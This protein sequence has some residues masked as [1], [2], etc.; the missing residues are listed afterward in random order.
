MIISEEDILKAHTCLKETQGDLEDAALLMGITK[1]KLKEIIEGSPVLNSVYGKRRKD[2]PY[3]PEQGAARSDLP[4]P[5]PNPPAVRMAEAMV[6]QEASLGQPLAALGFNPTEVKNI[7]SIEE[8]AGNHF[9]RSLSMLHGGMVKTSLRLIFQAQE[10]ERKY[11]NDPSLEQK[12]RDSWWEIY[13]RILENLRK[14]NEQASKAAL[15]RALIKG[16]KNGRP[17][18][19]G[20]QS[21]GNLIQITNPQNVTVNDPKSTGRAP[22]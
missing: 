13:F 20:F 5:I 17:A 10:I 22:Q 9:D 4:S 1:D 8:F 14:Q 11:L 7:L 18:Q 21:A 3:E 16:Q 12:D 2:I 15:T 19:P 6:V